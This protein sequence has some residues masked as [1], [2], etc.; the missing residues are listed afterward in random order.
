M[1]FLLPPIPQSLLAAEA[2]A[3][4]RC[5]LSGCW[6][7]GSSMFAELGA[8]LVAPLVGKRFQVSGASPVLRDEAGREP[9]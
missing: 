2:P 6:W 1:A 3:E 8:G 9:S 5:F 4:I 7:W